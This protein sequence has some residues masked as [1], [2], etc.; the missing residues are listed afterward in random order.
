M[1]L[2]ESA[3]QEL[4]RTLTADLNPALILSAPPEEAEAEPE[5]PAK[6]RRARKAAAEP[7]TTEPEE[8]AE[9]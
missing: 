6:P 5:A 4:T 8:T 3:V 1:V 2:T 7:E 9:P